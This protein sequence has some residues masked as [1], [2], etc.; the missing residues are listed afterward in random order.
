M[1]VAQLATRSLA[2]HPALPEAC[3][4]TS[5]LM[6]QPETRSASAA[7]MASWRASSGSS[8]SL[9]SAARARSLYARSTAMLWTCPSRRETV[10]VITFVCGRGFQKSN[11]LVIVQRVAVMPSNLG[12][13]VEAQL[14]VGRHVPL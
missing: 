1:A 3:R 8:S 10:A 14:M 4:H 7:A 13:V 9:S 11:V 2:L 6:W 12:V 5:A